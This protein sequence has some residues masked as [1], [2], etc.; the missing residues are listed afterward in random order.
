MRLVLSWLKEFV[1]IDASA[2]DVAGRLGLRGFEVAS[3][4]ARADGDA[5]M[6][7]EITANRPD[8]L[9]VLGLAR[10]AATAFDRPL[11]LPSADADARVRLA[12]L[13]VAGADGVRVTIEDEELCP[14][15]AALVAD[16]SLGPSPAWLAAGRGA[17]GVAPITPIVHVTNFLNLA[18]R[19]PGHAFLPARVAPLEV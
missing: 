13:P 4:E 15:Y 11:R 8:C 14:R 1:D 18:I 19:Q 17:A 6:D 5:V 3:V 12:A 16:V 9:S 7:F 2:D 10:E